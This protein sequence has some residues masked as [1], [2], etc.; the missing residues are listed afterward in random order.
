VAA[1]SVLGVEEEEEEDAGQDMP[2]GSEDESDGVGVE[3][4]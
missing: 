3:Y 1:V 2:D 4:F